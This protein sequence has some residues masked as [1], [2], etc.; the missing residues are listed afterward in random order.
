M[1][2]YVSPLLD[3]QA[4]RE[5]ARES[6]QCVTCIARPATDGCSTCRG[7]RKRAQLAAA[8]RYHRLR[9]LGLCVRCEEE[10]RGMTLCGTCGELANERARENHRRRKLEALGREHA[11]RVQRRTRAAR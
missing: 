5:G 3:L 6:G 4:R 11:A 9:E 1:S 10:A 2:R 7:C 8:A